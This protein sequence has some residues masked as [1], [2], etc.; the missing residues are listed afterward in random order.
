MEKLVPVS[1]RWDEPGADQDMVTGSWP[2]V[3]LAVHETVSPA[4]A[5]E[6]QLAVRTRV[7]E[8]MLTVK[9]WTDVETSLASVAWTVI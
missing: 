8:L 2:P 9:S 5:D 6:S 7:G 4:V 3:V 1:A